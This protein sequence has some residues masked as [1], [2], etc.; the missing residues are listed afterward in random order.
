MILFH[1]SITRIIYD[2][3]STKFTTKFAKYN[4]WMQCIIRFKAEFVNILQELLVSSV[5]KNMLFSEILPWF[6]T[7]IEE[8]VLC[9]LFISKFAKI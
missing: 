7:K 1:L 9:C 8:Q 2:V 6:L 3:T 5:A 4:A